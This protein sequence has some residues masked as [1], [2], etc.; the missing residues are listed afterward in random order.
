MQKRTTLGH[1]KYQSPFLVESAVH[2]KTQNCQFVSQ[3]TIDDPSSTYHIAKKYL[4]GNILQIKRSLWVCPKSCQWTL[5]C[6]WHP[7]PN[8][9]NCHWLSVQT[10][11]HNEEFLKGVWSNVAAGFFGSLDILGKK[12]TCCH[13]EKSESLRKK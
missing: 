4:T 3:P 9:K 12:K 13:I 7:I 2:K 11:S 10:F 8:I 1:Q 5:N 6:K